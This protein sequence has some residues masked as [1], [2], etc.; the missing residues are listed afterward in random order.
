MAQIIEDSGDDLP[1]LSEVVR[2]HG[3]AQSANNTRIGSRKEE[4]SSLAPRQADTISLTMISKFRGK[5]GISALD[6]GKSKPRKRVLYKTCDNPLLRPFDNGAKSKSAPLLKT[7]TSRTVSGP[8]PK[9]APQKSALVYS[10][11]GPSDFENGQDDIGDES[12]GLSDFV[13]MDSSFLDDEDSEEDVLPA[14]YAPRSTRKLV[15]GRRP[16]RQESSPPVKDALEGPSGTDE[17]STA[18]KRDQSLLDGSFRVKNSSIDNAKETQSRPT[19]HRHQSSISDL[20]EP[21][22]QL[23]L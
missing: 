20:D 7:P 23:S 15:R 2:R 18:T 4:L 5:D 3:K 8:K 19:Q 12:D 1:E 16:S 22:Y 14:K 6:T 13:V 10:S 11:D 21:P 9:I 17:N